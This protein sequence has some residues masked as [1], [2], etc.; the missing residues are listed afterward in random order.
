MYGSSLWET[1]ATQ[2]CGDPQGIL[3][4]SLP[5]TVM[6]CQSPN[7]YMLVLQRRM[8]CSPK[9]NMDL[10]KPFHA[11]VDAPPAPGQVSDQGQEGKHKVE[12]LLNCKTKRGVT[13]HLVRWR[14]HWSHVDGLRVDMGRGAASLP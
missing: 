11:Q 1:A 8:L 14:G 2:N 13:C 12:L 4:T 9:I 10:L 7:S 3:L 5:F 6:V